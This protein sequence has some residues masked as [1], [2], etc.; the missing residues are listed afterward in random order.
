MLLSW[1]VRACVH[2]HTRL[3]CACQGSSWRSSLLLS[4]VGRAWLGQ[5]NPSRGSL[6][7]RTHPVSLWVPVKSINNG[8]DGK[9][10]VTMGD[11]MQ[12][13]EGKH[14]LDQ[15]KIHKMTTDHQIK[16]EIESITFTTNTSTCYSFQTQEFRLQRKEYYCAIRNTLRQ[17]ACL[18][19]ERILTL[20]IPENSWEQEIFNISTDYKP[21]KCIARALRVYTVNSGWQ[22][23]TLKTL[24]V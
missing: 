2:T 21:W 18:Q 4:C 7:A 12:N 13:R 3:L 14:F 15:R 11:Q 22:V 10:K 6:A 5:T 19:P 9:R 23:R 1:A 16:H 17:P 24:I 8:N 20:R